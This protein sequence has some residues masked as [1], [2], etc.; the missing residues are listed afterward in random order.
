MLGYNTT[1]VT[2]ALEDDSSLDLVSR[3]L[4]WRSITLAGIASLTWRAWRRTIVTLLTWRTSISLLRRVASLL[5]TVAALRLLTVAAGRTLSVWLLL[6]VLVRW[7]RT[8]VALLWRA[9]RRAS[10]ASLLIFRIIA[11]INCAENQLD[12]PKIR[13]EIYRGISP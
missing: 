5:L 6:A 3:G 10:H 12:H 9:W 1:S 7:R 13:G 11:R 8:P 2:I 4:R